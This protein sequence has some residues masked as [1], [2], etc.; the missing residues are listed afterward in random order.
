[1]VLI[2][3]S[4]N[5]FRCS[6]DSPQPEYQRGLTSSDPSAKGTLDDQKGTLGA[7]FGTVDGCFGTP[8]GDQVD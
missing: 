7:S 1:M 2:R 6:K 8:D 4:Y 5:I 3:L